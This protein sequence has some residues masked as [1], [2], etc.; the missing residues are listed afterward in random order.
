LMLRLI[1]IIIAGIEVRKKLIFEPGS[2][3]RSWQHNFTCSFHHGKV[4]SAMLSLVAHSGKRS[5][6]RTYCGKK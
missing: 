2:T 4:N 1:V 6:F 3:R 5:G